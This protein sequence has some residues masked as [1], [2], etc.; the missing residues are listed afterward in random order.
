MN[1]VP[2][3]QL[4][5]ENVCRICNKD[6]AGPETLNIHKRTHTFSDSVHEKKNPTFSVPKI[7]LTW[8]I[9][10]KSVKNENG[11]KVKLI[12]KRNKLGSIQLPSNLEIKNTGGPCLVRIL[13]F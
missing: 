1:E 13:G 6:F 4:D 9:N 11:D 3:H 10:R 12:I 5:E 2:K 8:D 7:K